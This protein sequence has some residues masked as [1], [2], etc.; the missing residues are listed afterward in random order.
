MFNIAISQSIG[1]YEQLKKDANQSIR[2]PEAESLN[3]QKGNYIFELKNRSQ[4][5]MK[6]EK[7]I[8]TIMKVAAKVTK[9]KHNCPYIEASDK[10]L[11]QKLSVSTCSTKILNS[12]RK[13]KYGN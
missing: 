1:G 10:K 4:T 8:T 7:P 13:L 12:D 11:K 6:K 9:N 5:R 3:S 2:K